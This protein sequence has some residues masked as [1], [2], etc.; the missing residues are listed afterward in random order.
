MPQVTQLGRV[1]LGLAA[2]PFPAAPNQWPACTPCLCSSAFW[3]SFLPPSPPSLYLGQTTQG[4]AADG[5]YKGGR[6]GEVLSWNEGRNRWMW[7]A[8]PGE[9][10]SILP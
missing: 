6:C 4:E 3:A 10:G 7:D 8:L 5:F 2:G 9:W 1:G